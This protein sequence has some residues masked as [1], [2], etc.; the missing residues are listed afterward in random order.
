MLAGATL[1]VAVPAN[2]APA[3][4]PSALAAVTSFDVS[5]Y[6]IVGR[7]AL[8]T[9]LSSSAPVGSE[10]ATEVS[11]ITYN[12]DTDT[13]FV[14]GDEGTSVVQV[15]KTG[16]L[17]DS[18]TLT[19][20]ADTEGLTYIGGGQFVIAEERLRNAVLVTYVADSV[21]DWADADAVKLGTTIGNIGLEGIS[22]DP[23]TTDAN[24]LGFIGVKES[25]PLGVFQ[26]NIDFVAGTSS[27]GDAATENPTN[28]FDPTLVGTSDL[29]DVFPL[30]LLP[31]V[32]GGVSEHMLIISQEAGRIVNIG[33]DGVI[34]NQVDIVDAGGPLTV[35]AQT[36][37][38]VT[39]DRDGIMY[40]TAEGGGGSATLPQLL[41]WAPGASALARLAVTEVAPWGSDASYG[42]DWFEL[43]NTGG[44]TLDLTG[45]KIDDGSNN[46]ANAAAL[47]GVSQL[48]PGE[49][50][51]F[52]ETADLAA[53]SAAFT[54]AWF[55]ASGLPAGLQ[56]GS[57][58]GSGLGFSGGGDGV[59]IFASDNTRLT[60]VSF[61]AATPGVTFDN[62]ARL[63]AAAAPV[64]VSTLAVEGVNLAFVAD[65]DHATGSPGNVEFSTGGPSG[66]TSGIRITEVAAFGSGNGSY[67][68]DW[69]ELT[70]PGPE[71]V[72]LTGWRMDDG[73]AS[74]ASSVELVGVSVLPSGASAIFFEGTDDA[75][76]E[77]AFAQAWFNQNLFDSGFLFGRYSGSGVGLSTGGDS[78]VV[79]DSAGTVVTG[80]AFG[81]SPGT[82]PLAT[83]D[84]AAGLGTTAAPFPTL[85]TLSAVG[86]NGAFAAAQVSEI[87]S[88]GTAETP[89]P[90]LAD[91]AI[92][93][94]APWASGDAPYGADWF[95]L[96]NMGA[97]PVD[98]TGYAIDD[99][100]NLFANARALTGVPALAPGESAIFIESTTDA[101]PALTDDFLM[102]WLGLS[103]LPA[104]TQ[105]GNYSG[106]G[107][108][109]SSNGDQVNLF[110]PYERTVTGV[111]FGAST[112]GFT[113]DNTAGASG[114]LSTLSVDGVNGA[115][116]AFDNH[117]VGSPG[118]LAL[119]PA[120]VATI[121]SSAASPTNAS[122]ITF[123][124]T[125]D[126]AVT[127]LTIDDLTAGGS[128]NAT[129]GNLVGSGADYTVDATPANDGTVSVILAARSVEVAGAAAN[130]ETPS[131]TVEYDTVAPIIEGPVGGSV[132]A[133]TDP[134]QPFATVTFVVT[135]SDVLGQDV[136]VADVTRGDITLQADPTIEPVCTPA[137]GSQFPI[138]TTT[139]TCTAT[140]AAGN[141]RTLQFDVVVSDRETPVVDGV[142]GVTVQLAG[143][144]SQ[145]TLSYAPPSASDNSG[146]V[147]VVCSPDAGTSVPVG[148]YTITC[149]ATDPSGNSAT[150]AFNY[151]VNAAPG[152]TLPATG[153]GLSIVHLALTALLAGLVVV[154]ATRRRAVRAVVRR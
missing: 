47:T 115:F 142:A 21:L 55:G 67:A 13:L 29:S 98:L 74:F 154:V 150:T 126:Q 66:D 68:A 85:T 117:G 33:R 50:A 5:T 53:T 119:D 83:F 89:P 93:E 130:V 84:N 15:S 14:V 60:G 64:P 127:G 45:V 41:V 92:T 120:P 56:I 103:S 1:G 42:A 118:Q 51:I 35:P 140:D 104:G 36:M 63:G 133:D 90:P 54:T 72:N 31:D 106:S 27:N 153:G 97:E 30:S 137:S 141:M 32:D 79:F 17:I 9:H 3:D 138:G 70:N 18:M 136:D 22:Y 75:A 25:G 143:G 58:T 111:S 116:T 129:L 152:R 108:G 20:F 134:G 44:A 40:T 110:D 139:V 69:F 76:F 11:A 2:A 122:P 125:F 109:F 12:W 4:T 145:H 7:Y 39:V 38:G 48:A 91:L 52:L 59:N 78:V 71:S 82:A 73:S 10:L 46:A 131:S 77:L 23:L 107:I 81:A 101:L 147:T 16:A 19:G 151:A 123:A 80:V 95:E 88:P 146:S 94:V 26:T 132:A 86:V 57:Y 6:S 37:E 8:P 61:G 113:F 49:S 102:A 121:T 112:S 24:G 65:D 135:A 43:T 96:T 148:T 114:A 99:D 128:A 28:L 34:A 124:I 144:S 149:T 87:G 100:S 105:V 62:T